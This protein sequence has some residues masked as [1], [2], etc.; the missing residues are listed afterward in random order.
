MSA[1][2][3][4]PSPPRGPV[5]SHLP[6]LGA[7]PSSHPSV[8]F[9]RRQPLVAVRQLPP[10]VL[11]PRIWGGVLGYA[12][13][14][15]DMGWCPEIQDTVQNRLRSGQCVDISS[16]ISHGDGYAIVRATGCRLGCAL[17]DC[18]AAERV[19]RFKEPGSA[20]LPAIWRASQLV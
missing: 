2:N 5:V 8:V 7:R 9:L 14:S 13:V 12:V 11:G 15:W 1:G 10:W 20:E 4:G 3:D 16:V 19:G 17:R 18:G 6:V